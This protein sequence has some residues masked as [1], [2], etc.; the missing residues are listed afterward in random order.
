MSLGMWFLVALVWLS[1]VVTIIA[2]LTR[3]P[4]LATSSWEVHG[5]VQTYVVSPDGRRCQQTSRPVW[6]VMS[7]WMPSNT[8][9]DSHDGKGYL[10]TGAARIIDAEHALRVAKFA[11]LGEMGKDSDVMRVEATIN[12]REVSARWPF[13]DRYQDPRQYTRRVS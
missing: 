12:V 6:F 10:L 3:E 7:G 8:K 11:V 5:S 13:D 2:V 4:K 1:I 9:M